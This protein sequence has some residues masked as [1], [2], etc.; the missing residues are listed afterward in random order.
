MAEK[1][2]SKAASKSQSD[3]DKELKDGGGEEVAEKMKEGLEKGYFGP[4][5]PVIPNE[6]WSLESGPDSPS[7]EDTRLARAQADVGKG[8][9]R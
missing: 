7:A 6:E 3:L 9:R 2:E 8:I 1:S 4:D 5:E